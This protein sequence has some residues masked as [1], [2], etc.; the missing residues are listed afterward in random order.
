MTRL[1]LPFIHRFRDRHGKLRHYFRRPGF[2]QVPLPGFPGSA[3]FMEA[4][5]AALAG[6]GPRVE[7][8]ANRTRP[9]TVNAVVV[10]YYQSLTFRSLA[11]GTQKMRRAI[12]E[13][14]RVDH[15]DKRIA[16]LPREF[17]SRTLGKRSPAA[18]RNWLKT[19]RGLLQFAVA[20]GFRQDDPTR[21]VTLPP[22][23]SDGV[24]TWTEAEIGQFEA[25]HEIGSRARLALALLLYTAQRRGD[26][27]KIG[28]QHVRDN[29]L[30]VRQ[31]KTRATLEIPVHSDLRQ[32]IDATPGAHLTYLV[33]ANGEPFSP[34]GFGNWFRECC[35]AAGLPKGCSAH[36]LRKAACRR[37]A[38][39]GCTVHQIAAISGHR[40]LSEVQRYT[41]AADQ[42]RLAR[43]AMRTMQGA[44]T[45]EMRTASGKPDR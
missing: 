5:Q 20:E 42:A 45:T 1:K 19:L 32:V 2:K 38:E 41:R 16:T 37:L 15:G 43:E 39:A 25:T 34:A 22:L 6:E 23:K 11:P 24:H 27:V 12:L 30:H 28:R 4:Y 10:G 44:V 14:F 21:D 8:G 9:G 33:T 29:V 36:G 18:A 40:S 13:R 3:E 31:Q 7:I 17:I 26:V 35:D